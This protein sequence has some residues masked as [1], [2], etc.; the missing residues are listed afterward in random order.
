MAVTY[1]FLILVKKYPQNLKNYACKKSMYFSLDFV[2]YSIRYEQG[3]WGKVL[4]NRQNLLS[5]KKDKVKVFA[6]S[7]PKSMSSCS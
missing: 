3:V 2:W 7:V 5:A 4:L 1:K 6:D